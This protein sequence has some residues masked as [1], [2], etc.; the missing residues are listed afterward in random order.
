MVYE[1]VVLSLTL[2]GCLVKGCKHTARQKAG[3]DVECVYSTT[4]GS[5]FSTNVCGISL[6]LT[7]DTA[8]IP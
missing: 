2:V 3:E 7:K 6:F 1:M 5:S 8:V 4:L